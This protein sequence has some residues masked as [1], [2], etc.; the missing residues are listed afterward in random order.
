MSQITAVTA[1]VALAAATAKTIIEIAAP[2]TKALRVSEYWVD[3]DGVNGAEA[4]VVVEVLRKTA[5]ITGT[6]LT[7][8][9]KNQAEQDALATAKHTA[10][11][12]GTDGD[13]IYRHEIHP[14]GSKHVMFPLG[15]EIVVAKSGMLGI[16]CTAP[17]VVNV[18]AGFGWRE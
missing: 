15:D 9:A 11:A 17:A 2:S 1:E 13:V 16:R 5:T 10:T 3:F 6:T 18:V 4:P 8:R 12:E 14:Q 7:P